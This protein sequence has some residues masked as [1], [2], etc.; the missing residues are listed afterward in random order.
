M[1]SVQ[2]T[3]LLYALPEAEG[4]F[5][6]LRYCCYAFFGLKL[7]LEFRELNF[8]QLI[9]LVL[10][11]VPAIAA[12][13][14]VLL[15]LVLILVSISN[16]DVYKLLK[17]SFYV[18]TG[19]YVVIVPLS[20]FGMVPD[21]IFMRGETIRH[22]LGF[23]YPTVA[24][25]IYLVIVML[26]IAV[27]KLELSYPE[28]A[29]LELINLLLF[30]LTDGRLSFVLVTLI[31]VMTLLFKNEGLRSL[32]QRPAVLKLCRFV[33]CCLPLTLFLLT[34][35]LVTMYR[36]DVPIARFADSLLSHRLQLADA[37][38]Q[39]YGI[40]LFG[41]DI[42]WYGWGGSGYIEQD[43]D[44]KYN[45]VDNSYAYVLVDEGIYTLTIVLAGYSLLL[46]VLFRQQQWPLIFVICTVLLWSFVEHGL[47]QLRLNPA[48][49]IFAAAL[50][51]NNSDRRLYASCYRTIARKEGKQELI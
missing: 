22:S 39:E 19:V 51:N 7:L 29:L 2:K 25:S 14:L 44:F 46:M 9:V 40:S 13:S 34:Q 45:Y 17:V 20:L 1:M 10:S 12:R 49:V 42:K 27:R 43:P 4:V 6:V 3:T 37:A 41:A 48:L 26:Y 31:L 8:L 38:Y 28:T 47:I 32:V 24:I 50:V 21:W 35:L 15:L 33:T 18:V 16:L 5:R 36:N 11:A 30:K 23:F